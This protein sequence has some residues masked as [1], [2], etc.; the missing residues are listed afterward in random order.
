M[1]CA[2]RTQCQPDVFVL[3]GCALLWT[4]HWPEKGTVKDFAEAFYK[5]VWTFLTQAD[6]Y[7]V[8]DRYFDFSIKDCTRQERLG[9]VSKKHAFLLSTILPSQSTVLTSTHNKVQL[10]EIVGKYLVNNVRNNSNRLVITSR[11]F[12][13]TEIHMGENEKREDLYTSHEEADVIIPQQTMFAV[14]CGA[15][16]VRVI[17]DDTDVFI[18]LVHF[19]SL[20]KPCAKI[21]MEGTKAERAIIDIS[22]TAEKHKDIAS[23]LLAVHSLS[24]CDTVPQLFGIGKKSVVK[25]L[26]KLPITKLG[27][28]DEDIDSVIDE[29]KQFIAEC[30]GY[31]GETDM[32]EI[33][34]VKYFI[35]GSLIKKKILSA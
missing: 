4:V 8:F 23:S 33:R 27:K 5:K 22:K 19:T 31:P 7:L 30:Y 35:V 24:G 25:K 12:I 26:Y 28:L 9:K 20:F 18:I 29:A 32:S 10:I 2:K 17:C 13:P 11:D 16:C 14:D 15:K 21:Q 34:Y 1:E 3:D 6:V